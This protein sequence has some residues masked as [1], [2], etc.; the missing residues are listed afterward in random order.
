[1]AICAR[2]ESITGT[3]GTDV[4]GQVLA[5]ALKAGNQIWR[6]RD[7]PRFA[8]LTV[9]DGDDALAQIHVLVTHSKRFSLAQTS[10]KQHA[11]RCAVNQP[12]SVP[13]SVG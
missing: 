10:Q 12:T 7:K 11:K 9:T 5:V 4:I 6:E 13:G 2:E 3:A 8:K 1:V